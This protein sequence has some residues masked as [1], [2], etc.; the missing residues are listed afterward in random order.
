MI[1]DSSKLKLEILAIVP[2]GVC[3]FENR[4][5]VEFPVGIY[6]KLKVCNPSFSPPGKEPRPRAGLKVRTATIRSTKA[7]PTASSGGSLTY[8]R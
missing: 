6:M 4:K 5:Q 3:Q 7:P 1:S 2:L 8:R